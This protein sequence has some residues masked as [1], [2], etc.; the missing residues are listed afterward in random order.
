MI[1]DL[2]DGTLHFCR[3]RFNFFHMASLCLAVSVL[4]LLI[5]AALFISTPSTRKPVKKVEKGDEKGFTVKGIFNTNYG[6]DNGT[7]PGTIE[8]L[9]EM[10][11]QVG[12]FRSPIISA[13]L[14]RRRT[15]EFSSAG[16]HRAADR[17][18][19]PQGSLVARLPAVNESLLLTCCS[20]ERTIA[21]L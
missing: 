14:F 7:T 4:S 19:L 3:C 17:R 15:V 1:L 16:Q 8:S 13:A 12:S 6:L 10:K 2:C 11:Q 9:D 18:F 21:A 20:V 5:A